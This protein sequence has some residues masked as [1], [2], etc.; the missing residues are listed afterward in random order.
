[1][2]DGDGYGSDYTGS[3]TGT[4]TSTAIGQT[5]YNVDRSLAGTLRQSA[6]GGIYL[7]TGTGTSQRWT[8]FR[9]GTFLTD[10]GEGEF[11]RYALDA[12][13]NIVKSDVGSFA[14]GSTGSTGSYSYA[15]TQAAQDAQF[16]H[17]QTMAQLNAQLAEANAAADFARSAQ[18]QKELLAEQQRFQAEQNK[19][20][21]EAALKRERLGV[22]QNLVM[23]FMQSQQSAS[24]LLSQLQPDPFRFAAAAAGMPV[25]GTTPGAGYKQALTEYTQRP[26]PAVDVNASPE[27]LQ[28]TINTITGTQMPTTPG[29][30]GMSG[31][32]T[33]PMG[34]SGSFLVGE[35][36]PEVMEVSPY[37]VTVKP[38]MGGFAYGG[39]V[40]FDPSTMMASLAP[41]YGALGFRN[42]PRVRVNPGAYG[43]VSPLAGS[44]LS[45]RAW[46]DALGW[47]PRMVRNKATGEISYIEDDIMRPFKS[48]AQMKDWGIAG[49][50]W[51]QVLN[52]D[53]EVIAQ[54][55]WAKGP[56]MVTKPTV[57]AMTPNPLGALPM[58]YWDPTTK[59]ALAAPFRVSPGLRDLGYMEPQAYT[60]ATSAYGAGPW[61]LPLSSLESAMGR[62]PV[63]FN[64]SPLGFR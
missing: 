9:G 33:V 46:I 27:A 34:A 28:G 2:L 40:R 47:Q 58:P 26:V 60:T 56:R 21:E 11:Y 42:I 17:D 50:N 48:M 3:G 22:L 16:A 18:L 37:G 20:A 55:G 30:F 12:G 51:G 29:V 14:T 10:A 23:G 6:G 36:G 59:A 5:L 25:F 1:M 38:L 49:E 32:G 57:E 53:P 31:G 44:G 35:K 19:M 54:Y 8:P 13:G 15:G 62:L 52:L 4:G 61:G 64:R 39:G 7:V 63:G 45:G 43:Y 41:L 24:E